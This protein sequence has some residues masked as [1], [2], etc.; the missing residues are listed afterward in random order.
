MYAVWL[1]N[2]YPLPKNRAFVDFI[3]ERF[4]NGAPTWDGR[5]AKSRR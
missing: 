4:G 2:R 3:A 5:P 1:P